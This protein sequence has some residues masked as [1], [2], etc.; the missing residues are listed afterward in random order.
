V[1]IIRISVWFIGLQTAT[2][3]APSWI[4]DFYHVRAKPGEGLGAGGTGLELS[5]I[6]YLDALQESE[7]SHVIGHG[8]VSSEPQWWENAFSA[9]IGTIH[10][11]TP[12]ARRLILTTRDFAGQVP[13]LDKRTLALQR[14]GVKK[15][16]FLANSKNI[17]LEFASL[18][19]HWEY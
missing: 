5:K 14:W 16:E 7:I 19:N 17:V 10:R 13:R 6:D 15:F 11:P 3:I 1:E 4:F 18:E 12:I 8:P 9:K 2:G